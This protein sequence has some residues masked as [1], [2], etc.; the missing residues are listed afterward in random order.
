MYNFISTSTRGRDTKLNKYLQYS[1][2]DHTVVYI[3]ADVVIENICVIF[4]SK[5]N[6]YIL[7]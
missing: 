2:L 6:P 4:S 1:I 3:Y 7:D 5:I